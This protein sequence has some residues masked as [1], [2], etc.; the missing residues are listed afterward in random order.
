MNHLS[1]AA[2]FFAA[3]LIAGCG[4]SANG[5]V[6]T[7][8][9]AEAA[10]DDS[11]AAISGSYEIDPKHGYIAFSYLHKGLSRPIL[12]W[13]SW[14]STLD[15]DAE[16]PAASSV[17]VVIDAASVDSGVEDF[18]GHLQ[19]EMMFD[20]ANY[21]EI[22]FE[23]TEVTRNADNTGTVTGDLTIKGVTKPVTLEVTY[24][25]SLIDERS[26]SYAIGF[27]GTAN[28]KR[29]EFGI[30]FLVP[31]VGD[32]VTIMIETEYLMPAE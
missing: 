21:P 1:L 30:D 3:V 29:S 2:A 19:G 20:T 5:S 14:S 6:Q 4:Q 31:M 25:G 26:N 11:F 7:S 32:D 8:G 22:T 18:N 23:S 13:G 27:S 28:L 9:Q 12:R 24:N 15:W 17:S 10:T 16:N